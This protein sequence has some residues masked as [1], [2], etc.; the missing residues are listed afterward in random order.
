GVSLHESVDMSSRHANVVRRIALWARHDIEGR[1]IVVHLSNTSIVQTI[2]E[3]KGRNQC[4]PALTCNKKEVWQWCEQILLLVGR[5]GY[6]SITYCER[7][8][9]TTSF[10]KIVSF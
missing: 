5:G 7:P 4:I 6:A 8:M 9:H 1:V 3:V 10:V 2:S